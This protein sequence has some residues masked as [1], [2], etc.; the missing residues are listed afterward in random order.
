MARLFIARVYLQQSK[1]ETEALLLGRAIR[2]DA[3]SRSRV[4]QVNMPRDAAAPG[5][6]AG[7]GA[8]Q[9]WDATAVIERVSTKRP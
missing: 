5:A 3:E 7:L 6:D 2:N 9:C 8:G 4:K 1:K